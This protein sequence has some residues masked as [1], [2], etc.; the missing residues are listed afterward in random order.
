MGRKKHR[1]NGPK[2]VGR[3][4]KGMRRDGGGLKLSASVERSTMDAGCRL[5]N[6]G[7]QLQRAQHE[8]AREHAR[9]R[10]HHTKCWC[11]AC[12]RT[13]SNPQGTTGNGTIGCASRPLV[14]M[15][16]KLS[17]LPALSY[18]P[19]RSSTTAGF[20]V[21]ASSLAG[22]RWRSGPC[23]ACARLTARHVASAGGRGPGWFWTGRG[24]W[25]NRE[26]S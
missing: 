3:P 6:M 7:L 14:P 20:R 5:Y 24:T 17:G 18:C 22:C 21:S 23:S 11:A 13:L 26:G 15:I 16:A 12:R 8:A 1:I 2:P 9:E 10:A 19:A 4:K 25:G